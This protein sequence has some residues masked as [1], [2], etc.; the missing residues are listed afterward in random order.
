MV[1]PRCRWVHTVGMRFAIDVAFVDDAGTVTKIVR[2]KP[3]RL[4]VPV[5]GA[6]W[7][8][9]VATGSFERWGLAVGDVV[10][11]RDAAEH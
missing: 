4:G 9:E 3:W 7:V 1:I 8:I 6:T 2:M 10:E 5:R 11:L